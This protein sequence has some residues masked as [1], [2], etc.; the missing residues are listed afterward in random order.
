MALFVFL[1]VTVTTFEQNLYVVQAPNTTVGTGLVAVEIIDAASGTAIT[2]VSVVVNIPLGAPPA[3]TPHPAGSCA[4]FAPP[5]ECTERTPMLP[6]DGR[7]LAEFAGEALAR[8]S[9]A[10]RLQPAPFQ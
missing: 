6:G 1:G 7:R 10:H 3:P 4:A 5:L 8:T 9:T 2:N